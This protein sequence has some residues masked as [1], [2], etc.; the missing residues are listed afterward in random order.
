MAAPLGRRASNVRDT[1]SLMLS[2]KPRSQ[3]TMEDIIEHPIA[4]GYLLRF[5]EESVS[6]SCMH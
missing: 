4:I 3:V 1:P 2:K 6:F 5:C